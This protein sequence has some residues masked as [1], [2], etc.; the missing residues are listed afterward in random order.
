MKFRTRGSIYKVSFTNNISIISTDMNI[1]KIN[2]FYD[3]FVDRLG[4]PTDSTKLIE[5]LTFITTYSSDTSFNY[6]E[7]HHIL[8]RSPFKEHINDPSNLISLLYFDHIF[9]HELLAQAYNIRQFIRPLNFMKSNIAKDSKI[10]SKASK[11]GWV[12]LKNN[13]Q[14]YDKWKS[15]RIKYMKSLSTLDRQNRSLKAWDKIRADESKYLK[16]CA[17]NKENWTQDLKNKKSDQMKAYFKS[18]PSECSKRGIKRWQNIS[19]T[20]LEIFSNKVKES[21]S[22]PTV[23]NKISTKLKE[24]WKDPNFKNKMRNRKT[25]MHKYELISPSGEIFNRIGTFEIISEFDFSPSLVRKFTNCG[26]PVESKYLKNLQVRNTIGWII[27]K[28]N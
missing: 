5:Y 26:K 17:Q 13:I 12:N 9:A 7:K 2:E 21:L 3:V 23:K 8:P 19:K 22:D 1:K 11:K 16:R 6:S 15:G 25:Y 24:K 18:H 14:A 20:D 10:L 28:I 27:N 4:E